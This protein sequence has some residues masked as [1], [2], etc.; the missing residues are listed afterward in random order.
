MDLIDFLFVLF[1][2]CKM[3]THTH[4][5]QHRPLTISAATMNW[6]AVTYVEKRCLISLGW[7]GMVSIDLLKGSRSSMMPSK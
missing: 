5:P 4:I 7:I 3:L 6:S 2:S 1:F